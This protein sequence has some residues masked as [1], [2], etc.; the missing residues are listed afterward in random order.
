VIAALLN[1]DVQMAV[2]RWVTA[3]ALSLFSSSMTGGIALG[4]WLWGVAASNY[5]LPLTMTLSG[6]AVMATTLIGFLAPLRDGDAEGKDEGALAN[7]VKVEMGL[8]LRSGPVVVEVEYDVDPTAARSF[9][10]TMRKVQKI[11][12]RNG[13]FNW[14]LA[15][16]IARPEM[17]LERYNCPTWGDYLRMRGRYTQGDL[18]VQAEAE[19]FNRL[20]DGIRVRRWLER[21]YGSVRWQADS[22]DPFHTTSS[23][24]GGWLTSSTP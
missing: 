6:L 15:R 13:G 10:D 1:V 14:S 8:T 17:W 18:Q 23:P 4:A 7:E 11:R 9:Y 16:D 5:G 12:Q 19:E 20:A 24:D 3:R 22:P 2:P 21:P